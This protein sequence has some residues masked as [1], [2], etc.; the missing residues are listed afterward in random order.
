MKRFV[1]ALL[2]T[3][4]V[5]AQEAPL[6]TTS[7]NSVLVDAAVTGDQRV[8]EGLGREDFVVL[9]NGQPITIAG[10]AHDELPLDIV[11]VCRSVLVG[12]AA[13]PDPNGDNLPHYHMGAQAASVSQRLMNAAA[14]AVL[15]SRPGDRVAVVTYG[16]D[17]H[18]EL[19]FTSDRK[20]IANAIKR[21]G[22]A[23]DAD[24]NLVLTSEA[25]AI[26]Y[27]VRMIADVERDDP[28]ARTNRRRVIIMIS[29][30]DGVGT[31]YA[32][33]PII[34]RLWEQNI[35]LSVIEDLPPTQAIKSVQ[36]SSGGESQTILFRR[37]NPI[38]IA[39]ATGGDRIVAMDPQHP[40]DLLTPIRQRYTL[41]FNQPSD[42]TPGESRTIKVDLSEA[43]RRRFP[44]AVI[45]AREGYVTR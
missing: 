25:L 43:A 18:I 16:R 21:A 9:E 32:D 27:A 36:R 34:R 39:Q 23:D 30:V 7:T 37:Y 8:I 6:F 3:A 22:S 26:E 14:N 42:V 28:N 40:G 33:E 13:P 17:P 12:P 41:W 19:R 5:F 1:A 38:R 44:G 11:L 20:A 15:G 24:D 31:R 45:Q 35:I 2:I 29:N 4:P 10:M